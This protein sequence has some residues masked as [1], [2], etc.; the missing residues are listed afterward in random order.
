[1]IIKN[2]ALGE[3]AILGAG[4]FWCIEAVFQEL[5]GVIS[6]ESGYMGGN[7]I[8]P[9]YEQICTGSTGHAE[10]AKINFDPTIITFKD[11]LEVFWKTHD[12]TTLNQQGADKGTQYRSVVFYLTKEQEQLAQSY[13]N[14][15]NDAGAYKKLIVTEISE[16]TDYYPAED[17]HQNYYSLNSNQGYCQFVIKPKLEKLKQVF[18]NKIK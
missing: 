15:L 10:V 18:A 12:P 4:C 17:Y 5:K 11:L 14:K 1:M 13:K 2:T 8:N 3:T 6:V 16:A 7:I 9:T